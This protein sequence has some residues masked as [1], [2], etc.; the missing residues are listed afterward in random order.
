MAISYHSCRFPVEAYRAVMH[1]S[2]KM[3]LPIVPV[4]I[5]VEIKSDRIV[6][7]IITVIIIIGIIIFN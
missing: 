6:P 7:V 3:R 4:P 5:V 1:K 2:V